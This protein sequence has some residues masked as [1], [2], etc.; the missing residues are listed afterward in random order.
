MPY[1][2][3]SEFLTPEQIDAVFFSLPSS[4]QAAVMRAM[5]YVNFGAFELSVTP[6]E[7]LNYIRYR[8]THSPS[9]PARL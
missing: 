2:V 4:K 8:I 9:L 1:M 3:K 5:H 6:E 7:F